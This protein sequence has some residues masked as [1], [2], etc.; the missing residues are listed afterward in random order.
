MTKI[1]MN[2]NIQEIYVLGSKKLKLKEISPYCP[3]D[4]TK[5]H[6]KSLPK[7]TRGKT[8]KSWEKGDNE[9]FLSIVALMVAWMNFSLE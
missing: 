4:C 6:I 5:E 1:Y 3:E 2:N 7:F 9:R 8:A